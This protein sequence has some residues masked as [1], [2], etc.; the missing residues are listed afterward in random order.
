ME[1]R[2]LGRTGLS[3]SVL[4]LGT[5]TWGEQNTEEEGFAQMDYALDHGLNLFDNAELYPIPPK[6]ET[7]G[8]CEEIMGRWIKSRGARDKIIVATKVVGRSQN[9]WFRD[10]GRE[11]RLKAAD[12]EEACNKSLKRLQTDR[13]DLYQVHWVRS[14]AQP[15][16][17][18]PHRLQPAPAS[19]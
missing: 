1:H 9:T 14:R 5:M 6:A 7:Q 11:A 10:D 18:E 12:I 2:P 8:T 19:R 3:V 16:R 4:S 17:R 15:V 13:I